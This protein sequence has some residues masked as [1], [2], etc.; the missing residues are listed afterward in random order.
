SSGTQTVSTLFFGTTQKAA[1]TWGASGASHNNAAFTVGG[2]LTVTNGPATT[3]SLT[4]SPNPSCQG[5]NV[6]LTATVTG[7]AP[8]GTV[9]V[10]DSGNPIDGAVTLSGG[11]TA[12]LLVPGLT[13]GTHPIT[14]TYSGDDNNNSSTSNT[15]G[16]VVQPLQTWYQ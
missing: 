6:T 5:G 10:F 3:T 7:N 12:S 2:L 11:G 1:G 8:T 4:V 15:V 9:Q 14:A 13:V 16:E